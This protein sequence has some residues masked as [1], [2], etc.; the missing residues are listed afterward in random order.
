MHFKG[1]L[2]IQAVTEEQKIDC[3]CLVY[4]VKASCAM[5]D[6]GLVVCTRLQDKKMLYCT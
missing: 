3:C 5:T 2:L 1:N 6:Q 4:F